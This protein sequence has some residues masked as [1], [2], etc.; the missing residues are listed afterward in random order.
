MMSNIAKAMSKTFRDSAF[1][2]ARVAA[3]YKISATSYANQANM[4]IGRIFA[5]TTF[6]PLFRS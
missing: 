6:V 2:T 5:Q 3:G 4:A 1:N